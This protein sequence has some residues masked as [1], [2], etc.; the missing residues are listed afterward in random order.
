MRIVIVTAFYGPGMG[1]IENRLPPIFTEMGHEVHIVTSTAGVSAD[2][3]AAPVNRE[4]S[5]FTVHRLPSFN[6]RGRT[7]MKGLVRTMH[8]LKPDIV[9]TLDA[10]SIN[11]CAVAMAKPFLGYKLF[12]GQHCVYSV[13]LSSFQSPRLRTLAGHLLPI[14]RL[15]WWPHLFAVKCH[16]A[17]VDAAEI[18]YKYLGVPRKKVSIIP[19]GV[20]DEVFTP[21]ESAEDAARRT[22]I[23]TELGFSDS[24]IGCIYTGKFV[25]EKDPACLAR[26]ID[27]L[28]NQ[29]EPFK[30]VF[31][32]Q[33]P[34]TETIRACAG[35]QVLPLMP[36]DKLGD[37]YRACEIGVWPTQESM[38]MLDAAGCGLP[39]VISDRVFATERVDGNGLVYLQGDPDDLALK[40]HRLKHADVRQQLGSNG[41]QK[42]KEKFTWRIVAEQRLHDYEEALGNTALAASAH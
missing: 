16:A 7:C 19:L 35:C 28:A 33:G 36:H 6:L 9:Q 4:K 27:K 24:D 26:A 12:T 21:V 40:L 37:Y 5:G 39:I 31:I 22:A 10:V 42:I 41:A 17:T 32:G 23:R 30:G 13:F 14:L 8:R 1:Y 18:A 38:S 3:S 15:A 20:R 2:Q 29:G 34:Q 11:T 25:D